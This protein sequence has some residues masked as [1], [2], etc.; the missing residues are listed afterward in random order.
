MVENFSKYVQ[1]ATGR[2]RPGNPITFSRG[3]IEIQGYIGFYDYGM[4]NGEERG[5]LGIFTNDPQAR[6]LS[7]AALTINERPDRRDSSKNVYKLRFLINPQ[8]VP[9]QYRISMD[10]SKPIYPFLS[11]VR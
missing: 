11:R 1:L 5:I 10:V 3:D 7:D 4:H 2:N 9:I 6:L 8:D